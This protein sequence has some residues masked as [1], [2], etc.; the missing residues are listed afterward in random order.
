MKNLN[1]LL[2]G[3]GFTLMVS[4]I[5][6]PAYRVELEKNNKLDLKENIS[7]GISL[8]GSGMFLYSLYKLEEKK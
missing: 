5:V 2:V 4:G 1:N 6:Y 7:L 3:I 8:L